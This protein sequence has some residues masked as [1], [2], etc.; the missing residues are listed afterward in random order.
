MKKLMQ[1]ALLGAIPYMT[2]YADSNLTQN[3]PFV[4]DPI[5]KHFQK[6][7]EDM[8]RVIKEF[9]RDF[10][11]DVAISP[12]LKSH[13]SKL[14]MKADEDFVDKGDRYELKVE[15][16]GANEKGIKVDVK[17]NLLSIEAK[18]EQKREEKRDGK[19]VSQSTFVGVTQRAM[20]LPKDAKADS[21]KTDYKDGILTVTINKKK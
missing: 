16:P 13:F 15:L 9:N 8:N 7:N 12:N 6:L 21:L 20:S 14:S 4:N 11:N 3:D 2:L 10:F 5:F 19:V 18:T 17:D 1:I